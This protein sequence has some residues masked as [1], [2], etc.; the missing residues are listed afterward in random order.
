MEVLQSLQSSPFWVI[1]L[2]S[3][4]PKEGSAPRTNRRSKRAHS[5]APTLRLLLNS[6]ESTI[7]TLVMVWVQLRQQVTPYCPATKST[8]CFSYL[9]NLGW[10][11]KTMCKN[12]ELTFEDHLAIM[13][14]LDL[15]K[16]HSEPIMNEYQTK[17]SFKGESEFFV[18][19]T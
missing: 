7:K 18:N 13:P 12:C 2:L 6:E 14:A 11:W 8:D 16:N 19:F 3:I 17:T 5:P 15:R 4:V 10:I 1:F 9:M